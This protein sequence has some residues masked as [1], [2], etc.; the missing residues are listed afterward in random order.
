MSGFDVEQSALP[1]AQ[2]RTDQVHAQLQ[3]ALGDATARVTSLL[4][5]GWRG[6]AATAY[7]QAF[8]EWRSGAEE[9]L[10]GLTTMSQLLAQTAADYGASDTSSRTLMDKLGARLS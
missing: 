1:A 7:Q 6:P 4:G 10:A 2:A 9:V 5:S 8:D 3:S